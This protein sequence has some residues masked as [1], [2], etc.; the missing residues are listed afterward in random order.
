VWLFGRFSLKLTEYDL[1]RLSFSQYV[2]L[3]NRWEEEQ[4]NENEFQ[5]NI[6]GILSQIASMYATVNFKG[7]KQPKDFL[8]SRPKQIK[9]KPKQSEETMIKRA[10]AITKAL[11]GKVVENG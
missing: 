9:P 2:A 5:I 1:G 8:V 7:K 11:K 10:M 4:E 3:K 6:I